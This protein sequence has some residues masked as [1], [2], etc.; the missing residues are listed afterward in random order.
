MI[1]YSGD[2]IPNAHGDAFV[3]QRGSW[4]AT[5]KTGYCLSRILFEDG[6]PYGELK[7]VNF[8]DGEKVVGRPADCA[9]APDGSIL[10]SDDT[11]NKVY[12]LEYSGK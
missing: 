5:I 2:K 8:L 12:R 6:H 4:N 7:M 9:E 10:I 3:A 1:F 11:G